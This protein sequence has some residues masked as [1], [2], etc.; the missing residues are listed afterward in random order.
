MPNQ[1]VQGEIMEALIF[2]FCYHNHSERQTILD[3]FHREVTKQISLISLNLD[4]VIEIDESQLSILPDFSSSKKLVALMREWEELLEPQT[5]QIVR[6][7][8][9]EYYE[10]DVGE[11]L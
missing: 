2:L 6:L 7:I 3:V 11:A 9:K 4:K 8:E 10:G 5:Q 1:G